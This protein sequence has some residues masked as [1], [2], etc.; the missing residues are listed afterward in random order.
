MMGSHGADGADYGDDKEDHDRERGWHSPYPAQQ[1]RRRVRVLRY[2]RSAGCPARNAPRPVSAVRPI[3]AVGPVGSASRVIA[4]AAAHLVR[5]PGSPRV[6]EGV[7]PAVGAAVG[8]AAAPATA[9]RSIWWPSLAWAEGRGRA[10]PASA[11][12]GSRIAGREACALAVAAT[13]AE[14]A[15]LIACGPSAATRATRGGE[16]GATRGAGHAGFSLVP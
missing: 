1:R 3:S 4:G 15:I 13:A 10:W 14:T 2:R 16:V 8:S 12:R 7:S 5:A 9:G 6:V 11:I